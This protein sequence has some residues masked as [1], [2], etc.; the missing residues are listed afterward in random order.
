MHKLSCESST[1]MEERDELLTPSDSKINRHNSS[2]S[3]FSRIV[4]LHKYEM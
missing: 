2:K 4:L 3:H 1:V